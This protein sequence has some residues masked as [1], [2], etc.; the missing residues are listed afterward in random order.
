LSNSYDLT[1]TDG[2][3]LIIGNESKEFIVTDGKSIYKTGGQIIITSKAT[4]SVE[5]A[6]TNEIRNMTS[7]DEDAIPTLL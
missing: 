7:N 3:Y 1:N 4:T 5:E 2:K 6:V